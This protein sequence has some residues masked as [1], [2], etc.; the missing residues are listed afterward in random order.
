MS[1][2]I[3]Q[4]VGDYEIIRVLGKGGLGQV[5]EACHS[6]SQR[7]EALKVLLASDRSGKEMGER[8][9]REIQLLGV[10]SHPNIASLHNAFYHEGQ[11]VMVMEL[12]KGQTLRER[13]AKDRI[14]VAQ[15]LRYTGQVLS[16][17]DYAHGVGVV[18]RDVKPTNIMITHDDQTKLLDF[19]IAISDSSAELTAPGFMVGSV[20]Y[21]SPEQIAGDKATTRSD[22]YSVGVMLYEILTGKLPARG[23]NNFEIMRSHLNERPIPPAEIDPRLPD[24]LSDAILKSLEKIP[25]DRFATAREF[26]SALEAVTQ[27][28]IDELLSSPTRTLQVPSSRGSQPSLH[29]ANVASSAP[30]HHTPSQQTPTPQRSS[31]FVAPYPIDDVSKKLAVYIGPIASVVVRK[32]AAKCAS[33]D[34]LYKEAATQI[35]AEADRQRFLKS[36][37]K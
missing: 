33:L 22:I 35:P 11:L 25:A 7:C 32:L 14:P 4:R 21:M 31:R 1:F 3:G 29:S 5:Y 18:H 36:R 10:L 2:E 8:F 16:A 17:L 28:S 12:V 9:R 24:S 15:V 20:N 37:S 34:E 23:D 13:S 6:I 30:G 27:A 26:L 19:G